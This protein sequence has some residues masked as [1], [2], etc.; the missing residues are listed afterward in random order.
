M[1][2]EERDKEQIRGRGPDPVA[3]VGGMTSVMVVGAAILAL[4]LLAA[5]GDSGGRSSVYDTPALEYVEARLLKFGE[6][7]PTDALPD[8]IVPALPTAPEEVIALDKEENKPEVVKEEMVERKPERQPDAEVDDKLREVF[9][10]ARAFGEIQDDYVPEGHPDGVPGGDVTDPA[11]ASIGATYGHRIKLIF[12]E[13]WVVPTLLS[14]KT[15]ENLKMKINIKVDINMLIVS[16]DVQRKSGNAMFDES[17]MNAV[18]R[19]RSEVRNLPPPP[20][21][22]AANVFGAGINMTFHGKEARK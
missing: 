11:L 14:D 2:N 9:E 16:I 17:V 12:V 13:R 7:K 22:I 10:R 4:P 8:R 20:E 19:V 1:D 6:I 5:A 15:I 18:E 3:L 21:A